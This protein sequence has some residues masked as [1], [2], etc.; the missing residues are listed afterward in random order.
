MSTSELLSQ[1]LNQGKRSS[2]SS[3]HLKPLLERLSNEHISGIPL[4]QLDSP[5]MKQ[6]RQAKEEVPDALLFF[7]M[8]DFYELFGLDA[9]IAS[10][11][12]GLTLTSRDKS[13]ENPVP[14]AG[15]PVVSYK[16][17][18]KKCVLEGF[19]VAVCEQ[20][21]D[22]RQAKTIVKRE[23]TRI[24][25]PAVPGD[26]EDEESEGH[27][28]CYLSSVVKSKEL[29][30]FAFV[31][32]ATGEFRITDKLTSEQLKQEILTVSPRE[33]LVATQIQH[34]LLDML[35]DSIKH[36]PRISFLE[37]WILRSETL[38]QQLFEEFFPSE[39]YYE[40]GLNSIE[41]SLQAIAGL[42]SYLKNT[43]KTVLKNIQFISPYYVNEHLLIDEATKRHL[44]FFST[45]SGEK[46]GSLFGFLNQCLTPSGGRLLARRLNYPFKDK[47]HVQNS[48][49]VIEE[50]L[51]HSTQ[52]SKLVE[53]LKRASC[54]FERILSKAAQK[55]L[56]P[57]A[58][59]A[60]CSGLSGFL[61]LV[62]FILN[63]DSKYYF[64]KKEVE[65]F[66]SKFK[67]QQLFEL[68]ELIERA[69]VS[70]LSLGTGKTG[71]VFKEG[72]H[73]E[74][75]ELMDLE[76]NFHRKLEELEAFE[77]AKTQIQTLKIGYTR[78][79]GYYFEISK[80]KLSQVPSHFIRKQTLTN[81]ERFITVEL[82]ELE[83]KAL[84]AS[85]HKIALEKELLEGL[86][87]QILESSQEIMEASEL[88]AH[89]DV[90][91]NFASLS[92]KYHWCKPE[93]VEA[94]ICILKESVHPI[95][96]AFRGPLE[97]F[98]A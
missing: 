67:L 56:E 49:N 69:L 45:A 22:P 94:K 1:W 14:M 40:F 48:V 46:K 33:I 27:F 91:V 63:D 55:N 97:P 28:G 34:V 95:I 16:N 25:T 52:L 93:V 71:S 62:S 82:K 35:A 74:L 75:D 68:F 89:I 58:M 77:K 38:C 7:R 3:S 37:P 15:V 90:W 59:I 36:M 86:R 50:I 65:R 44:D 60:L 47:Q 23:I 72:F 6:F 10:D 57:K 53:L 96:Q 26:L 42:L 98:I 20:V 78:V 30:T 84:M 2:S 4:H 24:A 13:S 12:C 54:D 70:D 81:G 51:Q 19:K 31:D 18:L 64:L 66:K 88:L 39:R 17:A 5:M 73:P 8:G 9:I 87:L 92:A 76:K 80:G 79:F 21:E 41:E 43:Q 85:E 61:S 11:I 83:E 29:F 32:I